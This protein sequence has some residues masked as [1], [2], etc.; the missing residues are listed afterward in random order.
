MDLRCNAWGINNYTQDSSFCS[1]LTFFVA[2][3]IEQHQELWRIFDIL[4]DATEWEVQCLT[5][6]HCMTLMFA[7]AI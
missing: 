7:H 4:Y 5:Q 2:R 1:R 6:G 3:L